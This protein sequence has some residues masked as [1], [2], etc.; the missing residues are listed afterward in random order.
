MYLWGSAGITQNLT[1]T[2]PIH[3]HVHNDVFGETITIGTEVAGG[4]QTT[5]GTLQPGETLTV[6]VQ[7]MTGVFATCAQESTVSCLIKDAV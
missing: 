3:L 5:L 6:Q 7:G 2:R 1:F 4:T